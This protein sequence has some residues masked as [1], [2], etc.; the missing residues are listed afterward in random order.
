MDT[1][2]TVAVLLCS[3]V[4]ICL[5]LNEIAHKAQQKKLNRLLRYAAAFAS[6]HNLRFSSQEVLHNSVLAIDGVYRTLVYVKQDV[7]D[8]METMI[9]KLQDVRHCTVRTIHRSLYNGRHKKNR[10][11]MAR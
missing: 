1:M 7:G 4:V 5:T 8:Q 3:V 11:G 6:Q 9:V 10:T 2:V